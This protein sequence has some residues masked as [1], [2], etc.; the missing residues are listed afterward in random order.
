MD[1]AETRR[2]SCGVLVRDGRVLLGL[3]SRSAGSHHGRWDVIGGH[4]EPG[5]TDEQTMIRELYEELR[6]V[7]THYEHVGILTESFS[8]A[9][10]QISFFVF[11]FCCSATGEGYCFPFF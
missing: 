2:G 10:Y 11:P 9:L 3:R 4:R 8:D 1:E 6:V 5:E 7:P